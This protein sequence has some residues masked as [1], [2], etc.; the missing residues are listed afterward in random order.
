MARPRL[1]TLKAHRR[2]LLLAAL[3]LSILVSS[4]CGPR[5]GV[6]SARPLGGLLIACDPSDALLYVD[7]KYMGTVAGL[8]TKP[9]PLPVGLHRLELRKEGFFAHFAEITVAKGL[10]HK[11]EIKLRKEPF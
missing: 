8:A 5:T 11:L 7:D 3:A 2:A 4:A 6:E 9:L 10:R 1:D